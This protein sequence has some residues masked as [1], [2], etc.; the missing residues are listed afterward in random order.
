MPASPIPLATASPF[1]DAGNAGLLSGIVTSLVAGEDAT[2]GALGLG[3][4]KMLM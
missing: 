2:S 1:T 3:A 4:V